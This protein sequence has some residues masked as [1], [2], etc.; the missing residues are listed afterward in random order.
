LPEI[1]AFELPFYLDHG[2]TLSRPSRRWS[3][4]WRP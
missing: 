2:I 1:V 4:A 3:R